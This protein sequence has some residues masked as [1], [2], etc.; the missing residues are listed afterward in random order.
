[1]NLSHYLVKNINDLNIFHSIG[2]HYMLFGH[3]SLCYCGIFTYISRPDMEP[4][5]NQRLSDLAALIVK[6]AINKAV[7]IYQ[8][9]ILFYY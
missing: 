9:Y 7:T 1:M 8:K 4:G 3:I 2:T 6:D 5:E